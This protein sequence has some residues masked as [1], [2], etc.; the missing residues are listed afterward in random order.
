MTW[1]SRC[2]MIFSVT[3]VSVWT[4]LPKSTLW[5][6][7]ALPSQSAASSISSGLSSGNS[8]M[9]RKR[10]LQETAVE[11]LV[12][13][14]RQSLVRHPPGRQHRSGEHFGQRVAQLAGGDRYPGR[15]DIGAADR[16]ALEAV[17]RDGDDGAL[18]QATQGVQRGLDLPHLDAIAATLDQIGR[19][20]CRER[21]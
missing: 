5:Y 14:P 18:P 2:V 8:F 3:G 6:F 10:L 17:R 15:R 1:I 12:R 13:V 7:S 4:P 11:L 19:A 16:G 20:S 9:T 21:V